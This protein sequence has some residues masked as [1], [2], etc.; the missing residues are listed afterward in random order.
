MMQQHLLVSQRDQAHNYAAAGRVY[1]VVMPRLR[2]PEAGVPDG[3]GAAASQVHQL[4]AVSTLP[5]H[6]CDGILVSDAG[7]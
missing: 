1:A 4:L 5:A 2:E 3:E 6:A 7:D